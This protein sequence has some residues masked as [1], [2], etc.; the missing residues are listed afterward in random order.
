MAEVKSLQKLVEV[1][2]D[3]EIGQCRVQNLHAY[4][5][6]GPIHSN[7]RATGAHLEVCVVHYSRTPNSVSWTASRARR[8][9]AF[10]DV[11]TAAQVLKNLDLALNLLFLNRLEDLYNAILLPRRFYDIQPLKHLTV[12]PSA[13]LANDLV[14]F[15]ISP[16]ND[17]VLVIPI[18]SG[19]VHVHIGV[20][21]VQN[22]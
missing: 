7:L 11:D 1:V 6:S 16:C 19:A 18:L 10:D 12:F 9:E 8:P 14:V 2:P 5:E 22:E 15:L 13:N 4:I 20:Y 17:Q 21:P 3:V